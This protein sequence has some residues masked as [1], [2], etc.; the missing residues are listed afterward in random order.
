MEV[1]HLIR[2]STIAM[3]KSVGDSN[4]HKMTATKFGTDSEE[5]LLKWG[6]DHGVRT[7]LKI[8]CKSAFVCFL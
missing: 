1:L 6:K 8:A 3:V 2:D 4:I 5:L 7:K